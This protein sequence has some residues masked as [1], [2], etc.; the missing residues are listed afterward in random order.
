MKVSRAGV[1]VVGFDPALISYPEA[2]GPY[3]E[4]TLIDGSRLGVSTCR[5]E[6]GRVQARTRLGPEVRL[7]LDAIAGITVL[8]GAAAY[9]SD[10][11]PVASQFVPYLTNTP[12][13][14]YRRD[15]TWDG[16]HLR[17]AGRAYDRGLGMLPRTLLAYRIEPG[18]R[19]FRALVGLD[20]G[21]G[22][23]SSVIFR[24]LLDKREAFASPL[25]TRQDE[26]ISIDLDL[27]EAR[28]LIL[29]VE[30]GALGDVEDSADWVDASIIR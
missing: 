20:E 24:V 23:R 10:R 22:T 17:L 16:A 13:Q 5:I 9:L 25:M 30:F 4:L 1:Q 21:A 15:A 28:L 2:D 7:G 11:D 18:D 29:I 6:G 8:G 26:P 27:G 12:G 3:L 14:F 19:R